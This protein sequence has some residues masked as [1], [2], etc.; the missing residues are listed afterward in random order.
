MKSQNR[1][2]SL[3]LHVALVSLLLVFVAFGDGN[4]PD[5]QVDSV[6]V[7]P[8]ADDLDRELRRFEYKVEAGADF[9]V[10]RPVFD[11]ETFDRVASRLDAARLPVVL[12]VRPLEDALDAEWMAHEM[13]GSR[14]PS[15]VVER[16]RRTRTPEAA[17]AEGNAIAREVYEALKGRVQGV[18]I[19]VPHGRIDRALGILE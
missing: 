13:A 12:G 4:G 6:T 15:G 9:I 1:F 5:G 16:M 2:S 10:T 11:V 19:T 18:L 17:A 3:P 14:V 7:S 8:G